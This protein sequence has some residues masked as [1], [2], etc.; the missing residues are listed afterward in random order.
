MSSSAAKRRS[1]L[2]LGSIQVRAA[3]SAIPQLTPA[4]Q[5]LQHFYAKQK[6]ADASA[7]PHP[8]ARP[9]PALGKRGNAGPAPLQISEEDEEG[10]DGDSSLPPTPLPPDRVEL[11]PYEDVEKEDLPTLEVAWREVDDICRRCASPARSCTC[12]L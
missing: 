6:P 10:E 7:A 2:A 3:V 5:H 1:V 9:L 11:K 8:L 12:N 4:R